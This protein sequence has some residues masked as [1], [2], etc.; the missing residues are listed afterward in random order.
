MNDIPE[1]V[2]GLSL[3][4]LPLNL[5]GT[6]GRARKAIAQSIHGRDILVLL[7]GPPKSGKSTILNAVIAMLAKEP[8]R[9]IRLSNP[10]L[11]TWD[12]FDLAAALLGARCDGASEDIAASVIGRLG[13]TTEE[14]QVVI[15]VDDAHTL[16]DGAMELLLLIASPV[17][18]STVSPQLILAG[19]G[20]FWNREWRAEWR[21]ITS[22]ADHIALVPLAGSDARD[23]VAFELARSGGYATEIT[24]DALAKVVADSEGL[25]GRMI[26]IIGASIPI[27][28]CRATS[29]LDGEIVDAAIAS[30]ADAPGPTS[31][32]AS[33]LAADGAQSLELSRAPSTTVYQQG[34]GRPGIADYFRRRRADGSFRHSATSIQTG[35]A[36][37]RGPR[38]RA[39]SQQLPRGG[40]EWRGSQIDRT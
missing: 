10:E 26:E 28:H 13:V 23:F 4:G 9:F 6:R 5:G 29:V 21:V 11:T 17:R 32:A 16:S 40:G 1:V 3:G 18:G 14:S 12:Q 19:E 31:G 27:A 22:M 30:I 33:I 37:T 2:R 34:P 20:E 35:R 39:P 24:K 38:S 36:R 7:S 15:A 8:I 25:P